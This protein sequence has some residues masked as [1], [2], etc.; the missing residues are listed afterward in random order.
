MFRSFAE[1]ISLHYA[2]SV[3]N[4]TDYWQNNSLRDYSKHFGSN[5]TLVGGFNS[6]K[7]SKMFE[8]SLPDVTGINWVA[9]GMNYFVYEDITE[10]II[11]NEENLDRKTKYSGMFNEFENRK[12]RWREAAGKEPTLYEYLKNTYYKDQE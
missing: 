11:Q 6:L 10:K 5:K 4:D 12:N 2:L 9:A 1:F 8:Y 3:R 7:Q